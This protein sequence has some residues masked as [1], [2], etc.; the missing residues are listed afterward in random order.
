MHIS[1]GCHCGAIT[2]EAEV[3]PATVSLCHCTDCQIL[4]GTA[5]RCSVPAKKA[6]FRLLSGVPK[7]YV[8]VGESGARR[9]QGFCGNCGTPI[10]ATSAENPQAYGIRTGSARE[11]AQLL[12][13]TQI[14][15]RSALAWTTNI[16]NL[17]KSEK[18]PA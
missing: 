15:C 7:I 14:W 16:A 3:D 12:P 13:T 5:Y 1:G 2:Y 11:R 9:A 4:T 10:Y 8:K 18:S 17:P 6:D